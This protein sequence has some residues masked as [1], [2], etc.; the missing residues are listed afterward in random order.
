MGAAGVIIQHINDVGIVVKGQAGHEVCSSFIQI[1]QRI[2]LIVDFPHAVFLDR[3]NLV[4]H[5]FTDILV[6]LFPK[7]DQ[8]AENQQNR[9]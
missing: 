8:G 9:T 4:F 2:H 5:I 6:H 3:L 7:D 1:L